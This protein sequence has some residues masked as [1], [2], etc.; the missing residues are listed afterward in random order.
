MLQII[1][2]VISRQETFSVLNLC[3]SSIFDSSKLSSS[4]FINITQSYELEFLNKRHDV[5]IQDISLDLLD[6]DESFK[7]VYSSLSLFEYAGII[8]LHSEAG[9]QN[10]KNHYLKLSANKKTLLQYFTSNFDIEFCATASLANPFSLIVVL[11]NADGYAPSP[12]NVVKNLYDYHSAHKCDFKTAHNLNHYSDQLKDEVNSILPFIKQ[13]R[14][15]IDVGARHGVFTH[16]LLSNGFKKVTS[17]EVNPDFRESFFT[18]TDS[19]SVSFYN[20]GLFDKNTTINFEGRLGKGIKSV[21]AQGR[22][23]YSLDSFDLKEVDLIKIDVDGCDRQILRG[24]RRTIE[25]HKP[26]VFIETEEVQLK[27][28]PE[29]LSD[30]TQIYGYLLADLNYKVVFSDRNTLLIPND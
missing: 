14:H 28:D 8:I 19:K 10:E 20:L 9:F 30:L 6:T 7:S 5:L 25:A 21:G 24:C 11:R 4:S 27:H 15:A 2:Q 22:N 29:G 26:A 13:K 16:H 23:V 18:N 3:S 12:L 1:N 17:F